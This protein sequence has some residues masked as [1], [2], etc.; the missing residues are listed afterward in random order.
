MTHQEQDRMR[1]LAADLNALK[2][3][4][5]KRVDMTPEQIAEWQRAARMA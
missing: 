3:G 4:G 1:G 5:P 2:E